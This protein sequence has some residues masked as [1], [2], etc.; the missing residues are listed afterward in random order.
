VE[1]AA[2]KAVTEAVITIKVANFMLASLPG[3]N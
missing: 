1:G 2:I 3:V